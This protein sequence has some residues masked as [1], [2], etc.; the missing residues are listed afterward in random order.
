M[1][2]TDA[3]GNAI[4]ST[5][6]DVETTVTAFDPAGRTYCTIDG[7]NMAAYL[8]PHSGATYPYSCPTTPPTSPPSTGS[9]P[10]YVIS[11]F[12]A[13][14]RTLSS[15]D[16]DG[17]TTTYGFDAYGDNTSVTD[18]SGNVTNNCYYWQT[19]TCASGEPSAGGAAS[20]LRSTTRPDTSADPSGEET[21]YTYYPGG[22]ADE[23]TNPAGKT[24]DA[25]EA[26]GDTSSSSFSDTASGYATPTNVSYTY[27]QD[28]PKRR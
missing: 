1:S 21:K 28:E 22:A 13:A 10:G 6:P 15:S 16:A 26:N 12:D 11:I 8:A 17:N 24:T 14:G 3:D 23:T 7:A 4:Q 19:S 5:N 27:F 9:N 18:A 20:M 2:F 25:Y